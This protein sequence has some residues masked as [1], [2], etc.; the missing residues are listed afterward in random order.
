MSGYHRSSAEPMAIAP[1]ESFSS[2]TSSISQSLARPTL[3]SL[4]DTTSLSRSNL[5]PAVANVPSDHIRGYLHQKM[6]NNYLV[7][8]TLGEGSFAKVKE[9]FHILVGE[10]VSSH[11]K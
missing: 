10:K 4:T 5:P 11:I 1:G 2:S 6:V 7:G 9:A 8:S 3:L